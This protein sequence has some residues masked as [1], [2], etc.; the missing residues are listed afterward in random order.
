MKALLTALA[1]C[2]ATPAV[3]GEWRLLEL[4]YMSMDYGKII[5]HR[6][7]YLPY[8]DIGRDRYA[9]TDE[10]WRG[11]IGVNFDLNLIR[12]DEFYRFHWENRVEG[13]STYQQFREVAWAFRWGLQLGEHLELF[14]D[15]V[16]RHVL[17]A[18]P[19]RERTYP[20][21]NVYG[22]QITFYRRSQ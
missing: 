17:D 8:E 21:T 18:A 2:L 19:E 14:Y 9:E 3:A 10:T 22:G 4:D 13:S 20:L 6:D 7:V 16:S 5:N 1:L 11:R 15:H 12:W